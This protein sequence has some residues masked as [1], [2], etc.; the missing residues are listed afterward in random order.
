MLRVFISVVLLCLVAPVSASVSDW[1]KFELNQGKINF[2]VEVHGIKGVAVLDSTAQNNFIAQHFADEHASLLKKA[3]IITVRD[4][5]GER[6]VELYR[7]IPVKVFGTDITFRELTPVATEGAIVVF[8]VPFFRQ[9]IVQIDY[10]NAKL[11]LVSHSAL[12]MNKIAN[13]EMRSQRDPYKASAALDKD[14]TSL[15][16]L[17]VDIQNKPV[18]L[19]YDSRMS[20]GISLNSSTIEAEGFTVNSQTTEQRSVSTIDKVKVGPFELDAVLLSTSGEDMISSRG[21]RITTGTR[22][23]QNVE[24]SG[25]IGYDILKHFILTLDY[26]NDYAALHVPE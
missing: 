1:V 2:P 16:V 21:N 9:N 15:K 5:L 4:N 3:G 12:K 7:Q 14:D 13:V 26:K 22:V 18:W 8:G 6:R 19:T 10:P 11:R 17:K 24:S 25:A 20:E 23:E